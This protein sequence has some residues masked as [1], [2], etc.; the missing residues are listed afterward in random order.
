MTVFNKIIPVILAGGFGTRLQS[1]LKE[2]PKPMADVAGKPFLEW[3]L[4]FLKQNG[5]SQ[6]ILSTGYLSHVIE[7]YFGGEP[8]E[9]FDVRCVEEKEPLGTAG[10]F[11]NCIK[12]SNLEADA[13][14]VCNGDS[15]TLANLAPFLELANANNFTAAV[16]G[17]E[18]DDA[19]RYGTLKLNNQNRLEAFLEK[20]PGRGLINSGIYLFSDHI[21]RQFS[22]K[23]PLSFEM[24]VFPMLL[25]QEIPVHVFRA[26]APFIDI[27]IPETLQAS[28]DFIKANKHHF[29]EHDNNT[30]TL[31]N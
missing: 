8:I 15:M 31:T 6:S 4:R 21:V 1:V 12:K 23:M 25:M 28:G 14:L 3:I 10:G 9:G 29:Y 19:S 24:D 20:R 22:D 13:W 11:L 7:S 18:Q 26:E 30:S 17:V 2:V 5:F 27:G 16:F